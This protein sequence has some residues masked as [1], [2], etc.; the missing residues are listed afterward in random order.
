[1]QG[2]S[3]VIHPVRSFRWTHLVQRSTH[4]GHV[5][6]SVDAP[7]SRAVEAPGSSYQHPVVLLGEL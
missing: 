5:S 3:D 7:V 2:P 4:N 6:L 1:M